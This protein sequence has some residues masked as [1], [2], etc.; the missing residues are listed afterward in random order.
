MAAFEEAEAR[1]FYGRDALVAE[2]VGRL[3]RRVVGGGIQMVV[4]PSGAGKSSLLRAGLL[5]RLGAMALPGSARRPV[6]VLTPTADPL[7][8]LAGGICSLT[9]EDVEAV[10]AVLSVDPGACVPMLAR[11][12]AGRGGGDGEA[13]PD[14]VVVVVDQFEELFSLCGVASRRVA[15]VA[16]L[17]RL[18]T[19]HVGLV[20][21][22][23][24][25]DFFADCLAVDRLR[26]ALRD[27]PLLVGAMSAPQVREAIVCPAEDVG[28]EV[29]PGLVEVLLSDLGVSD[30]DAEGGYEVGRL[31]LLAHA[32]RAAWNNRD[33]VTLTVQGYRDTGGIRGAIAT[34]AERTFLALDDDGRRAARWMFLRL[35]RIGDGVHDTRQ[36]VR[37]ADLAQAG[38]SVEVVVNAFTEAR[39][40]TRDRDIVE[41]SHEA[42]LREWPR[43]RRWLDDDR[44]GRLTQQDLEEA[45]AAWQ[46]DRRDPAALYRGSRLDAAVTWAARS[47]SDEASRT[48]QAFLAASVRL[49]RRAARRRTALVTVLAV[50]LA[51]TGGAAVVATHYAA[52]ANGQRTLALPRQ[53]AAQS[54]LLLDVDPRLA[55]RLAATAWHLAPGVESRH[56]LLDTWSSAR[57][58]LTGQ[59]GAMASVAFSP[60][61]ALVAGAG[62]DGTVRLWRVSD[63]RP[64]GAPMT[65]HDGMVNAVAFSPDGGTLAS[66]GDDGTVRL[67]RVATRTPL[68]VW[69][70]HTQDAET[71]A[72]SPDG[73]MLASAGD[74]RVIRLRGITTSREDALAGHTTEI[75]S[76]AFSA[77]GARLLSADAGGAVRRW[78]VASGRGEVLVEG[79]DTDE[80]IEA[81]VLRPGS[82]TLA[83][84]GDGGEIRLWDAATGRGTTLEGHAGD[85]QSMAFSPDGRTLASAGSDTTARLW[86]VETGRGVTLEG[87][88]QDLTS[89]A[90]SPDGRSLAS[91]SE[92]GT[93]RLWDIGGSR[94]AVLRGATDDVRAV[95]V[96]PGGT[97]VAAAGDDGRPMLWRL[98]TRR[99]LDGPPTARLGRTLALAF[100]PDGG[101]LAAGGDDGRVRLWHLADRRPSVTV[102]DHAG[103]IRALAFSPD[104]GAVAV[105]GEGTAVG[106][107]RPAS[108]R[109][110]LLHG[111][112]DDV[113]AVAYSPDGALLAGGGDDATIRLWWAATGRPRGVPLT[114]HRADVRSVA[115]SPDGA[116]LASGSEDGTVR[117][118]DVAT[119]RQVGPDMTGHTGAVRSVV[120]HPGGATLASGGEDGTVRLWDVA[121][122]RQIGPDMTG[123]VG[124]VRSV[125]W[126]PDGATLVAGDEE[127]TIRLHDVRLPA[128]PFAK[129]CAIAAGSL[130]PRQW[131]R[132]LPDQP[133]L[134]V[135]PEP[136]GFQ[137]QSALDDLSEVDDVGRAQTQAGPG[138]GRRRGGGPGRAGGVLRP[139][140][141]ERGGPTGQRA[142]VVRRDARARG[143]GVR[144]GRRA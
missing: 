86:D 99:R 129:V 101:A 18:A 115:F 117:V 59:G 132:Y 52:T 100:S 74:D 143:G 44:A 25:A 19:G 40:L 109:R 24:R 92:D 144:A 57:D 95:A 93:I 73:G 60:D 3:D 12:L 61:G 72:F 27:D 69:I 38:E 37:T 63:R 120:W 135:C 98:A 103:Q 142:R 56:V 94:E 65:G 26:A 47:A 21:V 64:V 6:V 5:P 130:T 114:G 46:R 66:A 45:A 77:N 31:P 16:A 85:V 75:N 121:T 76:I 39:M 7:A 118:W 68:G 62:G 108:A 82:R 41:I 127:G 125:A 20:V 80:S 139:G 113:N 126:T 81:L 54:Q 28:L 17:S 51:L 58:V 50:L 23:L 110:V 1:W 102:A 137:E 91:A 11:A 53:L 141:T 133:Y 13:P 79:G 105:A 112:T 34:T 42:L 136:A 10:A 88:T 67:W 84:A 123:Y 104:G 9:G 128:D 55:A 90:F 89:V 107:W 78:D 14:R 111:N 122:H 70:R 8:A 33:G 43:L 116:V 131:A 2:L 4:A 87:H 119:H 36:R 48:A 138:R 106:V 35:V 97:M 15:F 49:R 140:G 29:E 71:I 22:A 96:H 30:R 134:R 83:R 32:L 124:I